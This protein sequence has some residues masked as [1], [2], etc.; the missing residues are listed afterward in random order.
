VDS[1]SKKPLFNTVAWGKARNVLKEILAGYAS[2][3]PG[4]ILY[5]KRLN[6]HGEVKTNKYGQQQYYC[7]RGIGLTEVH[8]KQ[9]VQSIGTLST[10]VEMSDAVRQEHRY[11]YNQRMS[12]R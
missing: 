11:Q 9:M 3:Q 5:L 1:E 6:D 10:G 2:D 12:K 8:H 7:L 4:V